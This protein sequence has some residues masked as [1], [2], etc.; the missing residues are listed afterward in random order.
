MPGATSE[1]RPHGLEQEMQRIEDKEAEAGIQQQRDDDHMT[2]L[3]PTQWRAKWQKDKEQWQQEHSHYKPR[4]DSSPPPIPSSSRGVATPETQQVG[5][6]AL[7]PKKIVQRRGSQERSERPRY[8]QVG[9]EYCG[10]SI[11][12]EPG[13]RNHHQ[14]RSHHCPFQL[15]C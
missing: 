3:P 12:G 13:M 5:S 7:N 15:S 1:S 10:R 14:L 6:C 11:F 2:A 8:M 4:G 9:G